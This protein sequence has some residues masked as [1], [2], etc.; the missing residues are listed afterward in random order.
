MNRTCEHLCPRFQ[1]AMAVLAKPWTGLI[2]ASLE[3]GPLR[4]SELGA[5]IPTIGDRILA[6]RLKELEAQGVVQRHVHPGPP[7]RVEYELTPAGH[8]F[9]AVYDAIAKW[10]TALA[11]ERKAERSTAG[12]SS[13]RRSG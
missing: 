10:G 12:H 4:Y 2:V 1:E 5:L 13:A 9:R 3:A 11:R 6:T 8:G 7:V